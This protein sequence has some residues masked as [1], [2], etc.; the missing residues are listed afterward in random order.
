MWCLRGP[1]ITFADVIHRT[2]EKIARRILTRARSQIIFAE[3]AEVAWPR[4]KA[5][6][7]SVLPHMMAKSNCMH[8][9]LCVMCL[10]FLK[11]F[12]S[13]FSCET[14]KKPCELMSC[15]NGGSCVIENEIPKC[16]CPNLRFIGTRCEIGKF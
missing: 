15:M 14:L 7:A 4:Q 3:T 10:E 9:A 8:Y 16:V 13:C 2:L 6:N 12:F 1:R 11:L 5:I